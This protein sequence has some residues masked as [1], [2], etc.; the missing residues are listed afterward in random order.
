MSDDFLSELERKHGGRTPP[1]RRP[2]QRR[3]LDDIL[4]GLGTGPTP[5]VLFGIDPER[6]RE[7]EP[8]LPVFPD[9]PVPGTISG[10][11]DELRSGASTAEEGTLPP[12]ELSM[13]AVEFPP[14]DS[15]RVASAQYNYETS[16]LYVTWVNRKAPWVYYDVPI[17]IFNSFIG[18]DSWGKYVN[19]VL[20]SYR[21]SPL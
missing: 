21:H 16:E 11:L 7:R 14:Y 4:A 12:P 10:I 5:D 3:T 18:S 6:R 15:T 8:D 2:G 1:P 13:S 17:S 19:Q 20:N 9:V